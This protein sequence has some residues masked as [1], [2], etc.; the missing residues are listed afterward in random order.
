[1]CTLYG[2]IFLEQMTTTM[3]T[4]RRY[5]IFQYPL[6]VKDRLELSLHIVGKVSLAPCTRI[7]LVL[8][9]RYSS[10]ILH[11]HAI[12]EDIH[13]KRNFLG[14]ARPVVVKG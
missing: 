5:Y 1:M 9:Y 12:N 8:L 4:Q 6:R 11:Y 13:G 7:C 3:C 2:P 10:C 14:K